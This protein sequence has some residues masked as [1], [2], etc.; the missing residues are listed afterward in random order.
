[1]STTDLI[2][3]VKDRV[4]ILTL[5]R[6]EKRN[7]LSPDM[8]DGLVKNL[9]AFARDPEIGAI[10]L[11]GAGKGFCAGGDVNAMKA[12]NENAETTLEQQI[13]SLRDRHE[14]PWLLHSI[15]KV[16]IAALNGAAAGAGLGMAMAC[17]LRVMSDQAR[18]T[19]AFSNIGYS[20]DFGVTWQLTTLLGPAKAKELMFMA[21]VINAEQ[22]LHLGLI[23]K[24][25]PHERLMDETMAVAGRIAAGPQLSYR[26]IKSN[27]N[28]AVTGDFRSLMDREAETQRRLG[29]SED[30]REGVAAFLEKR[31]PRYKGR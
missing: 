28:A 23:N 9:K 27:V 13:D 16:T 14:V 5:N 24:L 3:E 26:Y 31:A 6:P 11:T 7:A 17:D 25:A 10:V 30:H 15:P 12:R 19:T 29:L 4:G 20:G 22:A 8:E 18:L 21:D 2:V 1:M